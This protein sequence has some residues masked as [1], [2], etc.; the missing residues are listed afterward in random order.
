MTGLLYDIHGNMLALEAVLE[1]AAREGVQ[2]R[3]AS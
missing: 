2:S 3:P 1:D